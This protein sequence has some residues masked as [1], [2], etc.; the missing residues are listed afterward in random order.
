MTSNNVAGL[1]L[2]IVAGLLL[3]APAAADF[4]P[5]DSAIDVDGNS[6]DDLRVEACSDCGSAPNRLVHVAG[7]GSFRAG[8][9][10][11]WDLVDCDDALGATYASNGP[12]LPSLGEVYLVTSG[13]A[14]FG[15]LRYVGPNQGPP[16]AGMGLEWQSM[17]CTLPGVPSTNFI[18]ATYDLLAYFVDVSSNS[19]TWWDWRL[20]DGTLLSGAYPT[21]FH[22][23]ECFPLYPLGWF[24][25]VCLETSN[26]GGVGT[27]HADCLAGPDPAECCK[28]VW[29]WPV[30]S[31]IYA[32]DAPVD[33]DA[34][35]LA[36]LQVLAT[37]ECGDIPHKFR[38][39]GAVTWGV[40]TTSEPYWAIGLE[41]LPL[42]V[43]GTSD[44]CIPTADPWSTY[45][46]HATNSIVKV[47]VPAN[48]N[49][50]PTACIP[51][52]GSPFVRLAHEV[53]FEDCPAT[54][55]DLDA[56]Y[57]HDTVPFATTETH[58]AC[59]RLAYGPGY[60]IQGTVTAISGY[61]ILLRDGVSVP[62]GGEFAA[63]IGW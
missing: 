37:T 12:F 25:R 50:D 34:D 19:P 53:L 4:V 52:G 56:S 55:T 46:I 44:F 36:D 23:Y 2:R 54:V 21:V 11:A 40:A 57:A 13:G 15:K 42:T 1:A 61:E 17:T 5:R 29:S 6:A 43:S 49:S 9:S 8:T 58:E 51:A 38:V 7:S 14:H 45:V 28:D 48:K 24:A 63:R 31:T 10:T 62:S 22:V 16:S 32:P 39:E 26:A 30:P 35:G 20:G 18:F 47:W 60:L 59:F 3:A 41:D 33:L 27:P